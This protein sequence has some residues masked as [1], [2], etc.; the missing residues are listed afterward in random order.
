MAAKADPVPNMDVH[1]E[2]EV[3]RRSRA[4]NSA[5]LGAG[6]GCWPRALYCSSIDP[7]LFLYWRGCFFAQRGA[8]R[9]PWPEGRGRFVHVAFMGNL[10][11]C[12]SEGSSLH[13]LYRPIGRPFR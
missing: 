4:R 10:G 2:L 7:L 3:H 12:A 11:C 5:R 8:E 1:I 13:V 9:R 6:G